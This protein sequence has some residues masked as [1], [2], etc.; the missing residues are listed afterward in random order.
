M[1][2]DISLFSV[3]PL[4]KSVVIT[5]SSIVMLFLF[6]YCWFVDQNFTSSVSNVYLR[7]V[8]AYLFPYWRMAVQR[9]GRC[10]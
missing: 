7:F 3:W 2:K 8:F 9:C 1:E 6:L 5:V 10:L 4:L